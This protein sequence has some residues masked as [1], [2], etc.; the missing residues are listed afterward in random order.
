[1]NQIKTNRVIQIIYP[2]LVYFIV[3]QLGSSLLMDLY[4]AN[5]GRLMCLL[6]AALFC[7]VPM[8]IIY[9]GSPKIIPTKLDKNEIIKSLIWVIFVIAVGVLSNIVLTHSG[10]IQR[11]TNFSKASSTLSDGGLW[12]KLICNAL[13]IPILEELL[14]RG[15]IAGQLWLWY[16]PIQ[17]VVLSTICFGIIHNNIVQFIYAVIVGIALGAMY[18]KNK[19][20]WMCFLAHG[21]INLIAILFS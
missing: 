14:M 18:V 11:S 5:I 8:W 1:M 6:I 9:K 13:V 2:L 20:L 3:Y 4:A 19:R 21:L 10:L 7:L 12:L 17:A 16:G 15:I